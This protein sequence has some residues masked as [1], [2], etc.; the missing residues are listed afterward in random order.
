M[1]PDLGIEGL[2]GTSDVMRYVI[3]KV[4]QVAPTP[5]TVLLLGET[6]VGKS[7][8]A[9]SIHNLSP[10]RNR[11]LVTLNCAALPPTLVESELFG[12]E[13]GA[14]TGAQGRRVGRFEI[15]NAGTLFLDEI[16]DLPL[17]LQG[18][19]L[20]AVQEGEFERVGSN[21]T[22]KT[23]VRLIAATNRKLD[24]DVRAG[25]FRQ[26]LWYR[27]NVFPITVPPLRERRDDIPLL[28]NHFIEKHCRKMGRPLLQMS[29]ATMK[30]LQARDWLGNIRE[31][32]NVVER[33]VISSRGSRFEIDDDAS[34][35][36]DLLLA[37][38]APHNGSQT[39][40]RHE[41]DYIVA[42]LEQL[43][44]QVEGDGGVAEVLGINA[45]TLRGRMR[46][47][48]IRRPGSRPLP[49]PS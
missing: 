45:S 41:R 29:K 34:A 28:L 20:R 40:E 1:Q 30:A 18:K 14:F 8:I 22:V 26:D 13:K 42:T 46:K 7:L 44:W 3:S 5:S 31:L 33:A 4:Q 36:A 21:V 17:D 9:Q 37:V 2:I 19:L 23:D 43:H 24:D 47:H 48:G 27:L 35:S 6:G 12:H 32:E 11:P 38:T 10:R 49:P 16:G 25:R 15:A 39:L